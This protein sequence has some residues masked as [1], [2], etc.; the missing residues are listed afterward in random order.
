[1]YRKNLRISKS[2][3]KSRDYSLRMG[4]LFGPYSVGAIYP[5]DANTTVMIAG[6][7]PYRSFIREGR[8]RE[9]ED[10]RLQQYIGVRRLYS[11]PE[12]EGSG[13]AYVPALRFPNWLYC[14]R[15]ERMQYFGPTNTSN[16]LCCK[17]C[18]DKYHHTVKLVPERFVV[19]CPHGHI[20]SFPVMEWVHNGEDID[21][22][23]PNHIIYRHTKGGSTTMGDIEYRCSCGARRT[24]NGANTPGGLS[25]IGYH[26][27][28]RQPWLDKNSSIPC[29]AD[30][31]DLRVVIM[32]ATNVC[33]PDVVNSVLI[34]DAIDEKV[35]T[36]VN[37][38]FGSLLKMDCEG[39]LTNDI[40][41]MLARASDVNP[42]DF[43]LA[44]NQQKS[45]GDSGKSQT[46]V[47]YL[48]DEF[49]TL[50]DPH[51]SEKGKFVGTAIDVSK[52][53]LPALRSFISKV[54][55][56]ETLTVTRALV[57]FTRLN[58][59]YNDSKTM[60]ERRRVLSVGKLDWTLAN[61]N[62]GEGIFVELNNSRLGEWAN[63]AE[64]A[65]RISIM[66]ENLDVSRRER[67]LAPKILN[68]KYVVIHTLSH[69][70]IRGISEVCG[71]SAASLRERIYCQQFMNDDGME[72]FEDMH[73]LLIYTASS[74]GD[75][76]L[77]GLV[78]SGEPGRF[79]DIFL[80]AL[81]KATWCSDDPVCIES[82]GQGLD[83]CNL[84][85]CY[86]CTLLP[87]T[88]CENG[89]K[90]LDR[91]VVIGTLDDSE[92]GLFGNEVNGH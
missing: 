48:H 75:G 67:N 16:T 66:Q 25:M 86:N 42:D 12:D 11:P 91:G 21:P 36:A 56:V 47:E 45:S 92:V 84:A 53:G 49:L 83:S 4:Q 77:G 65:S 33:Y 38:Q 34:P 70:L 51:R 54:T 68:P 14:P 90:F 23:D 7:D 82:A 5:C 58:P 59:E 81:Q 17:S 69:L 37:K 19:V 63:R 26:C 55:L 60:E 30:N 32:G 79:E 50:R 85:A 64:V 40:L 24:L 1:M 43:R 73:G 39:R 22:R 71:Y 41:D 29:S 72:D 80:G 2:D 61:Q 44:Y 76:S 28:G 46:D 62:I 10:P 78:R 31:R 88:A 3:T 52:Y 13:S 9:V 18:T 15:C 20:D 35:R 57:G 6:L 8:L 89:N 87:E 74:S 27:K